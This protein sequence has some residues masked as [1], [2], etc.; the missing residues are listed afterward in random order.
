M[1]SIKTV[2]LKK[3]TS[4]SNI[5]ILQSYK[6]NTFLKKESKIKSLFKNL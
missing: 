4:N 5:T 2:M 1:N 3:N 6:V